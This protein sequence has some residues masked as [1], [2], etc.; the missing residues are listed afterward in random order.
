MKKFLPI[1]ELS[2]FRVAKVN[3]I[4]RGRKQKTREAGKAA[5]EM[6]GKSLFQP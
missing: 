2:F 4:A 1:A 5:G 6:L 3:G